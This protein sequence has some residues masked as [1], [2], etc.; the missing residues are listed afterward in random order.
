MELFSLMGEHDHE[1]VVFCQEP[2]CGYKGIIA[3]HNT[4]LGPALGGTRF[5]N[6][7]NDQE[8]FVDSLRLSRGMTYKASVAGLN[9]GGGKSVILGDPRSTNREEIFRAH[10]RFVETLKGRYITA[11]DVGTS[12]DDMEFVAMETEHVTGR[13]Q[14]SGDPSPVTA[15]GVYRGIKAAAMAKYG[16]D[17]LS[18]KRVTVQGVGHVGY[19]LCQ[20]L[21]SE[22]AR[23]VVTDIDQERVQRIVHEF[24]AEAVAPDAI[25]GVEADIYAPSALGATVNDDTIPLLKVDIVAGAAN[26]VLGE[27]RHGDD[28]HARGILYAPDYVIN[29][30]GLINVYGELNGWTAER[31]MRKAGDIYTTLLR[32][33]ELSA[34][35]GLPTYVAADR[36]AE[37]RIAAVGKIQ[38]TWV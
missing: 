9:L 35:A 8:A 33:F 22:G 11:E 24:G 13:A 30:G 4:V 28:L 37:E 6:Y 19:S 32:I 10:G 25:Y 17:S 2:S 14:T 18:G 16:S 15:Y 7:N 38:Q 1:Q 31:S 29:A 26:N 34:N 20:N 36:I 3:I 23:L 12:V 21:A 27:A 5:W